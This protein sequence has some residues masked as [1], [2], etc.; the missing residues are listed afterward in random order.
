[1]VIDS[2]VDSAQGLVGAWGTAGKDSFRVANTTLQRTHI[3]FGKPIYI[4]R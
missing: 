3:S 2:D 1:M 4:V